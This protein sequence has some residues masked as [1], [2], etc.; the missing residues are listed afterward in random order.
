MRKAGF[1]LACIIAILLP[2]ST[3]ADDKAQEEAMRSFLRKNPEI[4][5]E[6]VKDYLLKNPDVVQQIL[7]EMV[8]SKQG[9]SAAA[10][11]DYSNEI[12]ENAATLFNSPRQ[13]T[14][15]NP[16]GDVTLVEFFDYNCGYCKRALNDKI[17]LLKSDPKLKIVLKELP[18][19]G[20]ASVEAA[21]VAVAV[22]MQDPAGAKYLAFHRKLLSERRADKATALSAAR[23][24]GLDMDRIERDLDSEEVK[25]SLAE[26][27][28]LA[29]ALG[30][31]GTPSYVIGNSVIAGAV[32]HAALSNEIK[33]QRN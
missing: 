25:Q 10:K 22:R 31:N 14:L 32:G 11:R 1:A 17:E 13:V 4:V 19:L 15:G 12:K 6:I 7:S 18:V 27:L 29:R 8:K 5:Q 26:T 2:A 3:H 9:G 30:I 20:A 24:S 23:E 33:K 16:A 21:T 28:K